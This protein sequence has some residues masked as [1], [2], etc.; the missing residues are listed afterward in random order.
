MNQLLQVEK[1]YLE[2]KANLNAQRLQLEVCA[3][4]TELGPAL[5]T[6][7]GPLVWLGPYMC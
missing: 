6:G 4:M 5:M 7:L 3:G 2:L 1:E